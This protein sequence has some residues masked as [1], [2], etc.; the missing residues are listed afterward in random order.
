MGLL[1]AL[2]ICRNCSP[3]H[4]LWAYTTQGAT[5]IC[6]I[7]CFFQRREASQLNWRIPCVCSRAAWLPAGTVHRAVMRGVMA[8]SSLYFSTTLPFSALP[9]QIVEV[10]PLFFEVIE[11]MAFW[12]WAMSEAQQAS[13]ITVLVKKYRPPTAKT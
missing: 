6:V 11:R 8:Y 12:P 3:G 5:V 13:L 10:N 9:L 7:S 4:L 2:A 1:T